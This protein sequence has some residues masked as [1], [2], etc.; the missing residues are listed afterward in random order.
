VSKADVQWQEQAP[1]RSP[2]CCRLED[3][4]KTNCR[5]RHDYRWIYAMATF[6]TLPY[7]TAW[8]DANMMPEQPNRTEPNSQIIGA[9]RHP[10]AQPKI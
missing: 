4:L 7:N 9:R 2:Q 3:D 6:N 10:V 1:N 5:Q 8:R